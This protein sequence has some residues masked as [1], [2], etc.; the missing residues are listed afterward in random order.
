MSP[1]PDRFFHVRHVGL[2]DRPELL[3]STTDGF[4][5]D[6]K[7]LVFDFRGPQ[8]SYDFLIEVIEIAVRVFTGTDTQ[9]VPVASYLGRPAEATVGTSGSGRSI[10]VTANACILRDCDWEI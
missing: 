8:H 4:G 7:E 6:G 3:R 2:D 5:A 10:V 9:I 1:F